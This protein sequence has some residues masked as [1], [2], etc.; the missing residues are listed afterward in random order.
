MLF[1]RGRFYGCF[2][3]VVGQSIRHT[4]QVQNF[5]VNSHQGG[6][7]TQLFHR[8]AFRIKRLSVS[9]HKSHIHA[10][11]R[12]L[13]SGDINLALLGFGFRLGAVTRLPKRRIF[14]FR[15]VILIGCNWLS[16]AAAEQLL[17]RM[18]AR[19][20]AFFRLL[21]FKSH[22]GIHCNGGCECPD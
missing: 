7:V 2:W 1:R 6:T 12:F 18:V 20:N 10:L 11:R 15:I 14:R 3:L 5:L 13:I 8:V 22:K 17:V 21:G 9:G 19:P 4:G 16:I